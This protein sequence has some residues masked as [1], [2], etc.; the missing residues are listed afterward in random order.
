MTKENKKLAKKY[1]N[2]FDHW[3]NDGEILFYSENEWSK[4]KSDCIL[5]FNWDYPELIDAIV[6]NDEYVEFRKALAE[7]KIIQYKNDSGG[8]S[9]ITD[10]WFVDPVENYRIKPEEPKFK[11][12]DFVYYFEDC[13]AQVKSIGEIKEINP[14]GMCISNS[15]L[16][17]KSMLWDSIEKWE[18][19]PGEWCWFYDSTSDIPLLR[20]FKRV[21]G[22]TIE[23]G[24]GYFCYCE[25]FIGELPSNLKD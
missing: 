4:L 3:L 6:I 12:G 13:S 19:Q 1:K 8:W 24:S 17:N 7:G 5:A 22:Q 10:P 25:P 15:W 9:N 16:G 14:K 21:N 23:T 18:P 20:Q 2:E 11:V